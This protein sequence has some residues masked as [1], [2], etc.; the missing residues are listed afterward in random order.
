MSSL[1]SMFDQAIAGWADE[2]RRSPINE[3][4]VS[5]RITPRALALYLE[6]LRILFDSS[7][8]NL[9]AAAAKS[10]E[11]GL[12]DLAEYFAH[13]ARE[14]NGHAAWA[15]HD[16]NALPQGVASG[17]SS[18]NAVLKLVE[19]QSRA[20]VEHPYHYVGYSLLAESLTA[21]LGDEWLCALSVC[22]YQPAQLS[23]IAK[24][25]EA[26]R[27][28]T[29]QG[30]SEADALW[31]AGYPEADSVLRV[32]GEAKDLFMEFCDEICSEACRTC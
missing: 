15:K 9:R 28:H 12:H 11:L 4:A 19:L 16:L 20:I 27:E 24:H 17:I 32:M 1:A 10:R 22:G 25:L 29:K 30:L 18:A 21:Q 7:E 14:E 5:G 31:R 3:L 13:K 8:G 2:F 26:D 23:A 6:S